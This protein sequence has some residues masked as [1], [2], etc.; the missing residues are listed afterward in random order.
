[1]SRGL[2]RSFASAADPRERLYSLD[3]VEALVRRRTRLRRPAVAA[4][5]A[6][7]WGLPVLE[8]GITRI[9][10]GR[11]FY[12]DVDAV[13]FA[14]KATLEEAARLLVG[15]EPDPFASPPLGF[16]ATTV[17]LSGRKACRR[18]Q[19][20]SCAIQ[21]QKPADLPR[22]V[23]AIVRTLSAAA[24]GSDP[25]LRPIHLHLAQ[26]WFTRK[27]ATRSAALSCSAPTTNSAPRPS[28]S[29]LRLRQAPP[30][31]RR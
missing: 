9:Q 3:D 5:T 25:G 4:A 27:R 7:D 14:E 11:V 28:R 18:G 2:V 8:T 12:R 16:P 6:L 17:R 19:S 21:G 13:D 10:D 29:G 15:L 1:M 20:G 30:C 24:A 23:A 31:A 26:A 22:S